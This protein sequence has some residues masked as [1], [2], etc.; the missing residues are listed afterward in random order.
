MLKALHN[1]ESP[2][3]LEIAFHKYLEFLE[4][5]RDNDELDYRVKYAKVLLENAENLKEL[6]EGTDDIN[7]IIKNEIS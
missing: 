3:N 6:R 4:D 7:I 2:L 1:R 5:I